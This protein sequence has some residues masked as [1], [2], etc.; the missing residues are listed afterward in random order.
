MG[1]PG[2]CP[3][4]KPKETHTCQ[5]YY[6][7]CA[8]MLI[9][10]SSGLLPA[11]EMQTPATHFTIEKHGRLIEDPPGMPKPGPYY[12]AF[13]AMGEVPDSLNLSAPKSTELA[14]NEQQSDSRRP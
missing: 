14:P 9:L 8:A 10:T 3:E 11:E 6:S 12:T 2:N 5:E 13:A 1:M 7:L 4:S